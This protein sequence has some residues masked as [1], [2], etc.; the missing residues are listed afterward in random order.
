MI[1][2]GIDTTKIEPVMDDLFI[3]APSFVLAEQL[4]AQGLSEGKSLGT[5]PE[6]DLLF[7]DLDQTIKSQTDPSTFRKAKQAGQT[8]GK[9]ALKRIQGEVEPKLLAILNRHLEDGYGSFNQFKQAAVGL[10]KPAWKRVFEAGVRSAGIEGA[11]KGGLP[12]KPLVTLDPEDEKWLRGAMQHEMRFLNRML[13]AVDEETY[14]MPLPRRVQMYVR[15]LESFYDSARVIGLPATVIIHWSESHDE[16]TCV[17]CEYLFKNSPY[18]KRTLPTVPRAGMTPCLSN[19]RQR[20]V[21]R[22]SSPEK[23]VQ[24]TNRSKSR[25]AHIRNLRRLKQR[26]T[27]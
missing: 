6:L 20:L 25:D 16:R 18:T 7:L 5:A 13:R 15:T 9:R 27:L 8:V 21:I 12:T 1:V 2:A 26:G 23:V 14:V 19:C 4:R 22:Q 17:G 10:M 3:F 11:G 24:L